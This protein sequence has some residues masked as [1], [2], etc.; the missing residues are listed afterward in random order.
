MLLIVRKR[1]RSPTEALCSR[2]GEVTTRDQ[3]LYPSDLLQGVSGGCRNRLPVH[4][5]EQCRTGR[6]T[7]QNFVGLNVEGIEPTS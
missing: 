6:R 1:R 7:T 4:Q 2:N 5:P 3:R